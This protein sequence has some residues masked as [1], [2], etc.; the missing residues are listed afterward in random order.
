MAWPDL[1]DIRTNV[2][3]LINESTASRWTDAELNRWINDAERDI[4]IKANCYEAI[5]S[6]TTTASSRLVPFTGN[7]VMYIE[8]IPVSGT[9]I[10]LQAISPKS[11]GH[12]ST[13]ANTPQFWFQWGGNIVLEPIPDAA[14][15]LNVYTC[16]SP[17]YEMYDS[18][19]EPMIPVE[20]HNLIILYVMSQAYF[21]VGKYSMSGNLY[22]QYVAELQ[23]L[24][25]TY[26]KRVPDS[27]RDLK[28]PNM[29]QEA[30]DVQ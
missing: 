25:N 23:N 14:Y 27:Y 24:I 21:K 8:Y 6:V 16:K 29:V 15:T 17:D 26:Q 1:V 20:F 11:M 12:V 4:A 10:G 5:E 7:K 2:R 18:T 13:T 19:D 3:Y 28:V 9:I 30:Q 22:I